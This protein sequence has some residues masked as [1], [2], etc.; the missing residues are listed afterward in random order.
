MTATEYGGD[1]DSWFNA[2]YCLEHGIGVEK[3]VERAVTFYSHAA[4]NF[5]YFDAIAALGNL[6]MKGSGV[7]R[8]ASEAIYYF[9][10]ANAVGPWA[11]WMRRG[12]NQ[13]VQVSEKIIRF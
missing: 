7:V 13:Y 11:G 3:D 8:S 9:Q 4:K 12:F 2:G 1:S 6:H 10:V 5:G